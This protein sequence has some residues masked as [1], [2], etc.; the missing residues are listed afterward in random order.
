MTKVVREFTELIKNEVH[1]VFIEFVA[2]V[3]NFFNVAFGS[4]SLDD[5]LG[6]VCT[7]LVEPIK[8]FLTHAC[9]QNRYTTTTHDAADRH[10]ATRIVSG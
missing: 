1:R 8:T 3:I 6:R 7:P 2:R 5:I 10:S 4:D 9:W